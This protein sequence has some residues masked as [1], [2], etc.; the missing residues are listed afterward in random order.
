MFSLPRQVCDKYQACCLDAQHQHLKT[1]VIGLDSAKV[2]LDQRSQEVAHLALD[3]L[4]VKPDIGLA[5]T[6]G[7]LSIYQTAKTRNRTESG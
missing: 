6:E 5:K 1:V 7:S 3:L 2:Q 4:E